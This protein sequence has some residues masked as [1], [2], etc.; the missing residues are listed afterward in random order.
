M[1]TLLTFPGAFGEPSMS[2]FCVKAMILLDLAGADWQPEW[3]A[4][5]PRAS[6]GKLPALRTPDGLIPDS[7][8]IAAWLERQGAD[9]HR[10]MGPRDRATAHATLRMGEENLRYG[11]V[12]DRWARDDGWAAL[13]PVVFG[14]LPLPLRAVVPGMVRRGIVGMLQKTGVARYSEADRLRVMGA[15]LDALDTLLGDRPWVLSDVPTA[16]DA[17][18]LP[19][20]SALDRLPCDTPLRRLM[21]DHHRLM[22]YVARGR[23]ALYPQA[24]SVAAAA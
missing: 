9:L 18:V 1:L 12:H 7:N 2:P 8:F 5:P 13:R 3:T 20:L 21:R 19:L 16:L 22:A 4:L 24:M 17:A 11:L 15:D 10:G 14:D 23:A 6:Y